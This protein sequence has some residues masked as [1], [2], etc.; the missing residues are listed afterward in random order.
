MRVPS[1]SQSFLRHPLNH[2]L[3]TEGA[4][5]VLRELLASGNAVA[6]PRL[7]HATR[8]S[9]QTVR[10][11]LLGDLLTTGIV[12]T[13]GQGRATL[14]R[15]RVAHPLYAPLAQLFDMEQ[16]R[17]EHIVQTLVSSAKATAPD[18]LAVWIFGST[19]R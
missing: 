19:A 15:A 5:R 18:V 6:I 2:V 16:R 9:P 7:A 11:I 10:N 3:R 4:V 13:I 12:E 1:R 14:Y 8:L 17:F